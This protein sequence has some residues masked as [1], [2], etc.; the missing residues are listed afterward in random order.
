M[1]ANIIFLVC[2]IRLFRGKSTAAGFLQ[3]SPVLT[4]SGISRHLAWFVFNASAKQRHLTGTKTEQTKKA[5][6]AA[7]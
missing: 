1:T 6:D 7:A 4:W 2:S 5:A 3:L